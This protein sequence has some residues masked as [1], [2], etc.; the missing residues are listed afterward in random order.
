M[1]FRKRGFLVSL[2]F[3]LSVHI[4]LSLP[5]T[6]TVR[7]WF[8]SLQMKD[9]PYPG[10]KGNRKLFFTS[11]QG[12][13]CTFLLSFDVSQEAVEFTLRALAQVGPAYLLDLQAHL[14]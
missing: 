13:E 9:I 8:V 5:F 7:F 4:V 3:L 6:I 1:I 12:Q 14:T 11:K 10:C 2:G